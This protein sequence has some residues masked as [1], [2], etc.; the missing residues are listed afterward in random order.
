M[1]Y[2]RMVGWGYFL[3]TMEYLCLIYVDVFESDVVVM[4]SVD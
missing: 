1:G 3:G 2:I 4:G